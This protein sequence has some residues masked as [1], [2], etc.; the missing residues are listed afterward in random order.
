MKEKYLLHVCSVG[1]VST[2]YTHEVMA[3]EV[4]NELPDLDPFLRHGFVQ[5]GGSLESY[6]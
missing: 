4:E 5:F 6:A 2:I 3:A 1:R